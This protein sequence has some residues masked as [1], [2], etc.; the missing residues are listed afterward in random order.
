MIRTLAAYIPLYLPTLQFVTNN[1]HR[2]SELQ[3][4]R[5]GLASSLGF[6]QVSRLRVSQIARDS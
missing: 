6:I 3:S 4:Y 2:D 5:K 1:R